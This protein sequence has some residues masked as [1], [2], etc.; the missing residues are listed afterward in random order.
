MATKKKPESVLSKIPQSKELALVVLL[1]LSSITAASYYWST[2]NNSN[3]E[4]NLNNMVD[5]LLQDEG[6][7]HRNASEHQLWTENIELVSYNALTKPGNAEI[8]VANSPDGRTYAYQAGWKGFHII[9]VTDPSN[10]T[11]TAWYNDLSVLLQSV[12]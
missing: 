9:D 4:I 5:P 3:D 12:S 10:T 1:V 8:Q 7:N 11:V 6:H 2:D